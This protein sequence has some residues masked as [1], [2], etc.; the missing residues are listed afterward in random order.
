MEEAKRRLDK[1]RLE[2]EDLKDKL[3]QLADLA[4]AA[5]DR[6]LT[7]LQEKNQELAR[8]VIL[9]DKRINDL[10]VEIDALCVRLI[11]LYQPVAIDLRQVMTADH[12]IVEFERIGDLAANIAEEALTLAQYPR[13]TLHRDLNRMAQIAQGMIRD[14]LRAFFTRD[15]VLAREV[16]RQDDEVDYLDRALIQE[17]LADM[18]R[19][20]EA[21]EPGLSQINVVRNLERAADHATNIA[22]QVVYMVEGE[23]VRHRCQ[24]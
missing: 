17:L 14:S 6:S 8:R 4:V 10:E 23:N 16:C 20:R 7:A 5:L 11:A 21:L 2:L 3:L 9:E 19:G 12:L 22:E 24:W 15:A 1:F 13:E 18:A